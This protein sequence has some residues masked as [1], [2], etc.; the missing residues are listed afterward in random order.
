LSLNV[1]EKKVFFGD[2]SRKKIVVVLSIKILLFN[3][4]PLWNI[5]KGLFVE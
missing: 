5:L 3:K 1:E 2:F 4:K